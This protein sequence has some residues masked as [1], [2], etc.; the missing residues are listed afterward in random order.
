MVINDGLDWQVQEGVEAWMGICDM[1]HSGFAW[2]SSGLN[3][4][5]F[6]CDFLHSSH[7]HSHWV[8]NKKICA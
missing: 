3:L 7:E 4:R 6:R 8:N 2:L 5:A 1:P